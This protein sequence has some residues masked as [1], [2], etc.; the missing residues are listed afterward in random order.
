MCHTLEQANPWLSIEM[1]AEPNSTVSQ[2]VIYNRQGGLF[3]R[4]SPFQL[5]VGQSMG[6]YNSS[7]SMEC[8]MHDQI[9]PATRGP[10][11][12]DCGQ[13]TGTHVTIVL[14]GPSRILNLAE[15][16]L[17]SFF[18]SPSHPPPWRKNP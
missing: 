3:D 1:P 13:L 2:I 12:F 7:T 6:D 11:A 9:A 18:A 10:F 17:F 14:P 16:R 5:W 15:V 8:G 4:L